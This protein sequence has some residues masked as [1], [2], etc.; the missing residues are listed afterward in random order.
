[1]VDAEEFEVGNG[2]C[3][4]AQLVVRARLAAVRNERGLR[5]YVGFLL[6]PS[7]AS[8]SL[9]CPNIGGTGEKAVVEVPYPSN[10]RTVKRLGRVDGNPRSHGRGAASEDGS[11]V[12]GVPQIHH[13]I[14]GYFFQNGVQDR[15][16]VRHGIEAVGGGVPLSPSPNKTGVHQRDDVHVSP[17]DGTHLLNVTQHLRQRSIAPVRIAGGRPVRSA[18]V[19]YARYNFQ[20]RRP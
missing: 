9:V 15:P 5:R 8:L 4:I 3:A 12:G 19:R 1:M 13:T 18:V 16:L 2:G 17:P 11:L 20:P 6:G 10:R 14:G 7:K